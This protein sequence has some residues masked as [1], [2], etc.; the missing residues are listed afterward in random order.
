MIIRTKFAGISF[1][2]MTCCILQAT[3]QNTVQYW[4]TKPDQSLLLK[5]QKNLSFG[6]IT[7]N[8][9]VITIQPD[10][11]YQTIDGFGFALTGGSATL[12]N[13]LSPTTN[14]VLLNELFSRTGNSIGIS[15][16]RISIGASDLDPVV[17]SYDDLPAGET[18][19]DMKKFSI[20]KD[21]I[22]LIPVLKK[23]LAINPKIKIL[24]SPWS[25][26]EWMKDNKNSKGGILLPEHYE[27]YALY[28]VKYVQQMK[29]NGIVIDAVTVQ[30][31]PENPKNNPSLSMDAAQQL[32]FVRD[33]L[34]PAFKKAGIKTKIILF[35]HNCDHPE[36]PISILNDSVARK[37]ID[38]S[39]FHLYV[40]EV[41]AMSAV[42]NAHPD[43]NVYFTEQ[44]TGSKGSFDGDLQWAVKNVIIGTTRNWSRNALEW[45]LANDP[46][47]NPHTP[48][49]CTE[50]KGALTIDKNNIKRNV[51]YYII[52]H[53]SK[54]VTA[55]SVRIGSN[56]SNNLSN[57]A[58]RTPSGKI[59]LIVLN[60]NKTAT[61]FNISCKGKQV[62]ANL[63]AGAVATFTW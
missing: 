35:D 32:V 23:I 62:A 4:V 43:K 21:K 56:V 20:A 33:H 3:A 25:P 19:P 52:A 44:W 54:F 61:T 18:D 13:K 60:D 41:E 58:F 42:H 24:G 1:L 37:Y 16:L 59:V 51:S 11:V 39:A 5:Q 36:Y 12:I 22:D 30:N 26:P 9:P 31:E 15:Y 7:N 48:G 29:A 10:S 49:G 46:E 8:D 55:G 27:S 57:V 17:F 2:A 45:N 28:F 40:G 38:G 53:A 14:D 34:G 47:F 63:S 50:C 6:T